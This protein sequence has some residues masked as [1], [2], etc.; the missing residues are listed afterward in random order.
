[1]C[2]S[3]DEDDTF[4]KTLNFVLRV[5]KY[6]LSAAPP[7]SY[8][9]CKIYHILQHISHIIENRFSLSLSL[10]TFAEISHLVLAMCVAMSPHSNKSRAA[11]CRRYS[12]N[13]IKEARQR[14]EITKERERGRESEGER[15]GEREGIR[16]KGFSHNDIFPFL[17]SHLSIPSQASTVVS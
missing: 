17:L 1:M 15:E 9:T 11:Q 13:T 14:D 2:V 7:K 10:L 3:D 8:E 4:A 16:R 12:C 6:G 5:Y